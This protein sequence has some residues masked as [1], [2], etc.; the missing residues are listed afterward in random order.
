LC[1]EALKAHEVRLTETL[2][3]YAEEAWPR[4]K[5]VVQVVIGEKKGEGIRSVP[6]V[7]FGPFCIA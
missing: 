7:A 2:G 3:D 5:Y 6:Q 4:Y 1:K